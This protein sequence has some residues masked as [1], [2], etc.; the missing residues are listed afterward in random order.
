MKQLVLENIINDIMESNVIAFPN[1]AAKKKP[2]SDDIT[3]PAHMSTSDII[4]HTLK[5]HFGDDRHPDLVSIKAVKTKAGTKVSFPVSSSNAGH[6]DKT[7]W[8]EVY[9]NQKKFFNE[10]PQAL[11][12]IAKN[13]TITHTPVA[14]NTVDGYHWPGDPGRHNVEFIANYKQEGKDFHLKLNAELKR[15]GVPM[16]VYGDQDKIRY[17]K[18]G[19]KD[20]KVRPYPWNAEITPAHVTQVKQAIDDLNHNIVKDKSGWRGPGGTKPASEDPTHVADEVELRYKVKHK[21]VAL[22]K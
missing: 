18:D 9:G 2:D 8:S 17:N 7:D 22:V 21:S 19:T 3:F 15:R 6:Y 13:L 12:P 16:A 4:R 1:Q 14:G 5:N 10:L 20:V 11:A